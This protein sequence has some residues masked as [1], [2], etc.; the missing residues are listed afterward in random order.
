MGKL[1][2]SKRT[3]KSKLIAEAQV[4]VDRMRDVRLLLDHLLKQ[5][6]VTIKFILDCLYDVGSVNLINQKVRSQPLNQLT[7][8][9][10]VMSKPAFKLFALRWLNKN[11]PQLIT[12]WLYRKVS[13]D[14]PETQP[15]VTVT[16]VMEAQSTQTLA[17]IVDTA[18]PTEPTQLVERDRLVA[19][20]Q[21]A[22]RDRQIQQLRH[23]VRWL[24]GLLVGVI[25]LWGSSVVLPHYNPGSDSLQSLEKSQQ[26]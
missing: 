3:A 17:P 5:E 11:C 22:D 2:P 14:T 4:E 19:F 16:K 1:A 20:D 12:N 7:K 6:R 13:F 26:P 24:T 9:I 18:Q 23:Q 25:L 15:A 21:L 8:A 10:A